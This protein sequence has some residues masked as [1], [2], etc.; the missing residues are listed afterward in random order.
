[1]SEIDALIF[2][3]EAFYRAFADKDIHSLKAIWAEDKSVSCIHPGWNALDDREDIMQ[4][5]SQIIDGPAPP[6]IE[7]HAPQAT[8]HGDTGIVIC[9]EAIG[10][11]VLVAT[12]IFVRD[13]STWQM[14]HHH[15]GPASNLPLD[16]E[17]SDPVS[18]N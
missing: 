7:C 4:S 5:F 12:N 10:G 1:M 11:E 6:Q 8:I 13:G 18:I 15:A 3:N 16:P 14:V 9:Y 17:E 2:A